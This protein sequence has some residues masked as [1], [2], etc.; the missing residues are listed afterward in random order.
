MAN[1]NLGGAADPWP[2]TILCVYT[3]TYTCLLLPFY[4]STVKSAHPYC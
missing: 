4:Y 3:Y 1:K 2:Y